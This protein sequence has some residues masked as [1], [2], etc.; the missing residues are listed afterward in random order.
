[1]NNHYIGIMRTPPVLHVG[2]T[3]WNNMVL[4]CARI[5]IIEIEHK[6]RFMEALTSYYCSKVFE[7]TQGMN[8][9]NQILDKLEFYHVSGLQGAGDSENIC[10]ARF[11]ST[12][13]MYSCRGIQ[14]TKMFL[15]KDHFETVKLFKTQ[16]VK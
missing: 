7:D 1:M 8:E 14:Q 12:W 2:T 15:E 5:S 10:W 11:L 3:G 6:A 4:T 16:Q 9:Q 13:K